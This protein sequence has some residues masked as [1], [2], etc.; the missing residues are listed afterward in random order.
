MKILYVVDYYQ[1]E[2]GYSEYY[3]PHELHRMG[4]TVWIL[5]SNYYFPFPNYGSTSGKILGPRK[6]H[7]GR[8]TQKDGVKVIKEKLRF[9][10]FTRAIFFNHE[11]YVRELRPDIVI[12][13]KSS[14]FNV[15]RMAQLKKRW[16]YKLLSYDAHLP[17]GFYA[18]GNIYSKRIFYGLF[19]LFFSR[20]LNNEVDKFVAVQEATE[21]I[22]REFYG[23]TNI[24]HIPLGTDTKRF[25]FSESARNAV[26]SALKLKKND[27]V[28][29]Y[30][31][32]LIETKGTKL[33]FSAFNVIAKRYPQLHLLLVGN[34]AE[35]YMEACFGEVSPSLHSRIHIVGFQPN[36]KLYRFYSAADFGVWPLEES[37]AMNDLMACGRPFIANNTIGARVRLSNRN[38]LLYNKADVRDL[39]A[40]MS[41]FVKEGKLRREMGKR[42]HALVEKKL[43]WRKIVLEYLSYVS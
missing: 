42:G 6:H 43:T 3:I 29:L 5:S 14:G 15:I 32:K 1:P 9:E 40:K 7:A 27:V 11:K 36:E 19:R 8:Y 16:R 4:H 35:E 12:V 41:K 24:V 21:E 10:I 13:N 23:Q 18:V 20:L 28:A 37:T 22:M 31:G 30:S 2:L 17:S 39:A 26:R 38:A 33:L 25:H 34:G